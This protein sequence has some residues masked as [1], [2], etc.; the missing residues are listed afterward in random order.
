VAGLQEEL[1]RTR[2]GPGLCYQCRRHRAWPARSGGIV[3]RSGESPRTLDLAFSQP[4]SQPV[5]LSA[6]T[7][8]HLA[9]GRHR[10]ESLQFLLLHSLV[11]PQST[12]APAER[13]PRRVRIATMNTM[14]LNYYVERSDYES[15][16]SHSPTGDCSSRSSSSSS[17]DSLMQPY[18]RQVRKRFHTLLGS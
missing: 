13:K 15:Y 16:G 10:F 14:A 8:S 4:A 1:A 9:P 3:C 17:E 11:K 5:A 2:T 18:S 7:Q 6:P 12:T